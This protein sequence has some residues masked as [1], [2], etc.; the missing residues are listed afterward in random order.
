MPYSG[1]RSTRLVVQVA[2]TPAA[3]FSE[4]T[5]LPASS[6]ATHRVT[7]GHDTSV[8][9]L[10]GWYFSTFF[11]RQVALAPAP[12]FAELTAFPRLSSVTHSDTEGQDKPIRPAP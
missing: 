4:L 5:V 8:K 6:T 1:L 2:E 9:N 10:P 3:G 12:G 7:D 11:L